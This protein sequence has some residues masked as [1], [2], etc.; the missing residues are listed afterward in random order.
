[1]EGR[2]RELR[3][4]RLTRAHGPGHRAQNSTAPQTAQRPK[5]HRAQN[6]TPPVSFS[7]TGVTFRRVG[8]SRDTG[9]GV[10]DGHPQVDD[11][12]VNTGSRTRRAGL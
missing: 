7:L 12:Q 10:Q 5:Q 1:V 2:I 6:S 9:G 11:D 4:R 3:G 8:V